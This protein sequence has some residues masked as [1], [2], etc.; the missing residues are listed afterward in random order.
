MALAESVRRS[1]VDTKKTFATGATTAPVRKAW[2]ESRITSALGTR[3]VLAVSTLACA[4][5]SKGG[6]RKT[7][8]KATVTG[9][10]VAMRETSVAGLRLGSSSPMGP[11]GRRPSLGPTKTCRLVGAAGYG[12]CGGR[13]HGARSC[14]NGAAKA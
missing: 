4:A 8:T 13:S 9:Y 6:G 12:V 11:E 10:S 14:E 1:C 3:L 2:S 5:P 7:T